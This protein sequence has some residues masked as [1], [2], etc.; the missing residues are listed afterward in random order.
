[1]SCHIGEEGGVLHLLLIHHTLCL[2]IHQKIWLEH[3]IGYRGGQIIDSHHRGRLLDAD[4]DMVASGLPGHLDAVADIARNSEVIHI[5]LPGEAGLLV[6]HLR[7]GTCAAGGNDRSLTCNRDLLALLIGAD[8]T[9]DTALIVLEDF[10]GG[11][12]Q[13]ILDTQFKTMIIQSLIHKGSC[14]GTDALIRLDDVPGGLTL[15]E[16]LIGALE[17]DTHVVQPL[18]GLCGLFEIALDQ[19]AVNIVVG[20]LHKHAEGLLHADVI[21]L[22]LLV[23]G[24]DAQGAHAHIGSAAH[25]GILLHQNNICA[26]LCSL[27][28]SGEACGTTC[29]NNYLCLKISH[30]LPLYS[31]SLPW[32]I[33]ST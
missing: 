11:S 18:D 3:H 20:V 1:M 10:L 23:L 19:T 15:G 16:V 4:G 33:C 26:I 7:I 25:G 22:A 27:H 6:N 14:T 12:L 21:H 32:G 17:L 9:A 2:L 24:S 8:H 29:N 31:F 13:H 5:L 30:F 28:S